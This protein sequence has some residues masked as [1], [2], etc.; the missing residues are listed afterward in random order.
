[1]APDDREFLWDVGLLDPINAE[2]LDEALGGTDLMQRL[3]RLADLSGLIESV[4]GNAGRGR[5]LHLA[6]RLKLPL[7]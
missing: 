3:N 5:S 4:G 7:H 6:N 1:M 2:L